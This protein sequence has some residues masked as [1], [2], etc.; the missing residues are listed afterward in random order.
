MKLFL[1][2]SLPFALC[3]GGTLAGQAELAAPGTAGGSRCLLGGSAVCGGCRGSAV[4]ASPTLPRGCQC[5]FL[6]IW[7]PSLLQD[8]PWSMKLAL[9][10]PSC[11]SPG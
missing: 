6:L 10:H 4:L 1:P 7:G 2:P 3:G 11:F 8:M 5:T 9:C